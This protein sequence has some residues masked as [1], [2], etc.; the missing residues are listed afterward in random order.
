MDSELLSAAKPDLVLTLASQVLNSKFVFNCSGKVK[1]AAEVFKDE[2]AAI[3]AKKR[4]LR[5]NF[6][7]D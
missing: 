6:R 3:L 1:A 2:K 4:P 5:K 7:L